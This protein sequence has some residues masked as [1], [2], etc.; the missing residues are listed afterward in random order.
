M[1]DTKV[2]SFIRESIGVLVAYIH[3]QAA[4]VILK[5]FTAMLEGSINTDALEDS[6][7]PE[8][9]ETEDRNSFASETNQTISEE[10]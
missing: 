6:K 2:F 9:P 7:E 8:I 4:L 5:Q 3:T 10:K 1:S